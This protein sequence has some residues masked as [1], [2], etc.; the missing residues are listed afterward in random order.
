[1]SKRDIGEFRVSSFGIGIASCLIFAWLLYHV[2]SSRMEPAKQE[3]GPT[4]TI[5]HL[6]KRA[7]KLEEQA[8]TD[9][10]RIEAL[11]REVETLKASRGPSITRDRKHEKHSQ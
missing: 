10:R 2:L 5:D 1:M 8:A 9:R 4:A 6:L 3:Q 11:E 7:E